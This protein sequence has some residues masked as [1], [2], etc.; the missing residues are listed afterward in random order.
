MICFKLRVVIEYSINSTAMSSAQHYTMSKFLLWRKWAL[1]RNTII[2][3]MNNLHMCYLIKFL[4]IC[5]T[6][7]KSK[8][9]KNNKIL[10]EEVLKVLK[11]E[12]SLIELN[13]G[14]MY[15]IDSAARSKHTSSLLSNIRET[16]SPWFI[17]MDGCII[18]TC[19]T[20]PPKWIDKHLWRER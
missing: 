19:F 20:K 6:R 10:L 11:L 14:K 3:I 16:V 9:I 13:T 7:K 12:Q 17:A 8:L 2:P 15:K 18:I 1:E 5:A 4:K